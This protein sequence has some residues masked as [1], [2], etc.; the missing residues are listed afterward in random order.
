MELEYVPGMQFGQLQG[1]HQV[2][3]YMTAL[4]QVKTGMTLGVSLLLRAV[5]APPT[6]AS[7]CWQALAL[8]HEKAR[9]VHR[10]VKPANIQASFVP[11]GGICVHLRQHLTLL[12][13]S[14][15]SS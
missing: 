2:K 15:S 6:Y 10:D 8:L 3:A 1:L 11:S 12:C 9:L 14:S 4:I 13:A 5:A 7:C